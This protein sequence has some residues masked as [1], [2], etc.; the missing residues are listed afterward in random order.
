[1]ARQQPKHD[2]GHGNRPG[3]QKQVKKDMAD[4]NAI[5]VSGTPSVYVNGK[6]VKHRNEVVIQKM[7]NE[8]L[9]KTKRN[10]K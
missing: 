10:K 2:S 4:G 8:A 5:G 7:I 6:K 9:A 1:M 3:S